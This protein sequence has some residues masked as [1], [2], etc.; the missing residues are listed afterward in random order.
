M[1]GTT[2]E[3]A[4][5]ISKLGGVE[6]NLGKGKP[7]EGGSSASV[8]VSSS[9][10]L[11]AAGRAERLK[12]RTEARPMS[13]SGKWTFF[14]GWEMG[15]DGSDRERKWRWLLVRW[16]SSGGVGME[17]V[18]V[19]DLSED[20]RGFPFGR[21]IDDERDGCGREEGIGGEEGEGE[22][23]RRGKGTGGGS[24]KGPCERGFVVCSSGE[25]DDDKERSSVSSWM[26][27]VGDLRPWA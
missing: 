8:S 4:V 3:M 14:G 7:V 16:G 13:V 19:D 26:W 17:R 18:E 10:V 20:L 27:N 15:V 25:S 6:E 9:G 11:T 21:M 12:I 23:E 2:D 5:S 24:C 22:G 1:T